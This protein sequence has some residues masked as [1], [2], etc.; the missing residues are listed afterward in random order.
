[1]FMAHRAGDRFVD[2]L[3]G[4]TN[5]RLVGKIEL[6]A[7]D[8]GLVGDGFGMKLEHHGITDSAGGFDG[9]VDAGGYLGCNRGNVIGG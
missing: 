3:V 2:A 6:D 7:S 9:L 8:I 1:M 5:G 4:L